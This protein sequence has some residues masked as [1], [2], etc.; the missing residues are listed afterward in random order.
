MATFTVME[1]RDG[2]EYDAEFVRD[3]FF[4]VAFLFPLPWLLWHRLWLT[5]AAYVVL[6]L[7]LVGAGWLL[8]MDENVSLVLLAL[9]LLVGLEASSLKLHALRADG[10]GDWGVVEAS[11]PREA[12]LRYL[13]EAGHLD[14]EAE[15]AAVLPARYTE[16][17]AGGPALGLLAYP[18]GR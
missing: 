9:N 4:V 12:E 13:S 7:V 11:D 3:G 17:P 18:G 15:T 1:R 8:S 2:G 14:S 10:W 16:A 6:C 5:S